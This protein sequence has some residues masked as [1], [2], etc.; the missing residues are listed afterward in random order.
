MKVLLVIMILALAACGLEPKERV[1]YKDVPA[2]PPPP[3]TGGGGPASGAPTWSEIQVIVGESCGINGCHANASFLA[4]EAGF[5][6]SNSGN[7]ILNG[8]MPPRYADNYDLWQDGT[9]KARVV[10]FLR[11]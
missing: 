8:S 2:G 5:R 3:R 9:R 6:N 4:T 10:Q 11:K 1:V 7:R